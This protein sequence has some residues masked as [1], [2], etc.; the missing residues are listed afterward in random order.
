MKRVYSSNNSNRSINS[1]QAKRICASTPIQ[2]ENDL[3]S[4]INND[5][6]DSSAVRNKKKDDQC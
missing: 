5:T 6:N 1:S 3:G 2:E 4:L